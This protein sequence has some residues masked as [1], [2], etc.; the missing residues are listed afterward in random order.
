MLTLAGA[1][2]RIAALNWSATGR[3]EFW[4]EAMWLSALAIIPLL[5][6]YRSSLATYDEAKSYGL[7]FF[8]LI[9]VVLLTWDAAARYM[10]ARRRGEPVESI[11]VFGWL[12][13][14]QANLLI[15]ATA[16]FTFVNVVSTVLSPMP[17]FSFWGV[18]PASSGYNLYSFLSM[19]V[20]FFAVVTKMRSVAQVWR[21]LHVI[22]GVGTLTAIYGTAQHFGWDPLYGSQE[23]NRIFGS[24]GNPI[25]FGAYLVMTIPVTMVV[26]IRLILRQADKRVFACIV[27]AFTLQLA[28]MW[29]TGSRG[30][31]VGLVVGLI[32]VAA[33]TVLLV[34][35]K[36]LLSLVIFAGSSLLLA[37][38]LILAPGEKVGAR[39]LQ[40]GGELSSLTTSDGTGRIE[41]GLGGRAEIWGEV[42]DL[43]VEWD[44]LPP[45]EGTSKL[46]RPLFGF[47]PDML[48]F[49]SSLVSKP[50][51]SLEI[52]DHT[53]NRALHVLMEQGW[54]GFVV[55]LSV[56]GLAIWLLALTWR[57]LFSERANTDI[58]IEVLPFIAVAGAL[59]ATGVEQLTGVGRASD[60]ITS[61]VLIG[62]LI[63]LYRSVTKLR[64][65]ESVAGMP[66]N[67]PSTRSR[68]QALDN[69]TPLSGLAFGAGLI[70]AV[71]AVAVFFLV[72]GQM[73]MASRIM[74]GKTSAV[75]ANEV[76]QTFN[77]TR[78]TAPQVEQ[79]TTFTADILIKDARKGLEIGEQRAAADSAETA[80][81]ILL[82]YH[83]R[84]PLAIRTRILLAETAALLVEIGAVD[85]TE[86]MVFRY[87]QLALQFPNEAEVL[88]VVANAYASAEM[89]DESLAMA[90]RSIALEA[91]T[92]PIPQAWWVKGK[93]Y[94][95]LH[96]EDDAIA[97]FET[98]IEHD[99]ES[100]FA[101]LSHLD[102]AAIYDKNSD[103]A[104]AEAHRA[105]AAEIS[106]AEVASTP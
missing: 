11:D 88:A 82:E 18:A 92:R 65:L 34:P 35:R 40:F 101:R 46:L 70:V 43:A 77:R 63:V 90:D 61:W 54:V 37:L 74:F 23:S 85:Y 100:E 80:F 57:T 10:E 87:E 42:L 94:E 71:V 99:P 32:F 36:Q 86:E 16:V 76:Y 51:A 83:N 69:E 2:N 89:Y 52:V 31:L 47:G 96:Q 13:A 59:V 30:P 21:A 5:F 64:K 33:S 103:T 6:S 20:I 67:G 8:A 97:A 79:F 98:A 22:V 27:V 104:L 17:Y 29:F 91:V 106:D 95:R 28:A 50:R 19:M 38:G 84:N 44:R 105:A 53:H 102:L 60:L 26:G 15:A 58:A 7:H 14:D 24:F 81:G 25:Y 1:R 39:S 66:M 12:K 75:D 9:T 48:R 4:F 73:L 45:D 62:V 55:F 68:R 49:S 78:E 72:D 3:L 93:V 41:P 56:V